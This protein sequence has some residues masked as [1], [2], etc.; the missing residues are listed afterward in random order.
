MCGNGVA[1]RLRGEP[2]SR[3]GTGTNAAA[4]RNLGVSTGKDWRLAAPS[5]R[6]ME[7]PMAGSS[8]RACPL[9]T[10]SWLVNIVDCLRFLTPT[11]TC[12]PGPPVPSRAM[13]MLR[14]M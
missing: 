4:N 13:S 7:S 3:R 12:V 14:G 11:Y 2:A 6:F 8:I 5:G 9:A 10:G 1:L